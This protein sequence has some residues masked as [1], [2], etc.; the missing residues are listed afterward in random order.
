MQTLEEKIKNFVKEQGIEVVGLAGPERFKGPKPPSMNPAYILKGAKSIVS[1]VMPMNVEAI[2]DWFTKKSNV[3]HQVDQTNL[4]QE[5]GQKSKA[6]AE[7]IQNMGYKAKAVGTNNNYRRSPDVMS[8]R[9]EFSHRFG[10]IAAGVGG[11][12]WSGNIM[13][14]AYGAAVYLGTVVTTAELKSDPALDPR[15]FI[16]DY[17]Y[18]CRLCDKTCVSGMFDSQEE[19]YV[20]L[21]EDL[22]PR[23]KRISID[24]CNT[25]CFA[26][27]SLSRDKKWSTW[28][29]HWIDSWVDNPPVDGENARIKKDLII[30]GTQIGDATPKYDIIRHITNTV[31]PDDLMAEYN[32]K[33]SSLKTQKE[34]NAFLSDWA[35]RIGVKNVKE[36]RFLVCGNCA[37]ICGPTLEETRKRYDMLV[38]SGI[39]IPGPDEENLIVHSY[40]EAVEKRQE[41]FPK[42]TKAEMAKDAAESAALWARLYLGTNPTEE[43]KGR[44]YEKQRLAAVKKLEGQTRISDGKTAK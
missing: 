28:G 19:E 40:E 27:H 15:Y 9:P 22:H 43:H 25:S 3:T 21:N 39:V 36:D 33:M 16:E 34:R 6:I 1:F 17:C 12:G 18:K 44:V 42:V 38:N 37:L 30:K 26:L 4:N 41:H 23:A 32:E 31:I 14:K 24:L 29:I 20:L 2:Y 13:T 11:Q 5:M 8:T 35:E 10:A 7:F